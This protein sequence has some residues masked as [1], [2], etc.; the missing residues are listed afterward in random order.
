MSYHA[1]NV[2]S[3][4]CKTFETETI[5]ATQVYPGLYQKQLLAQV[6]HIFQGGYSG[7]ILFYKWAEVLM[8]MLFNI[9]KKMGSLT[10]LISK[11]FK[12]LLESGG[13]K[14][15]WNCIQKFQRKEQKV[16]SLLKDIFG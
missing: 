13:K 8:Q 9:S 12:T 5:K 16:E 7:W 1:E 11:K 2:K 15:Q 10:P 4:R 14:T 6:S 3:R